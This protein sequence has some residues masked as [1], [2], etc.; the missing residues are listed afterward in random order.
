M[1]CFGRFGIWSERLSR[2]FIRKGAQKIRRIADQTRLLISV[3]ITNAGWIGWSARAFMH[4]AVTNGDGR[5]HLRGVCREASSDSHPKHDSEGSP[6]H[7]PYLKKALDR[8]LSK[9]AD[10]IVSLALGDNLSG[11]DNALIDDGHV[12]STIDQAPCPTL[13]WMKCHPRLIA[14]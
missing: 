4:S 13:S 11:W 5:C 1:S 3:R 10:W 2:P 7:A 14:V 8:L 9:A 12:E 6:S